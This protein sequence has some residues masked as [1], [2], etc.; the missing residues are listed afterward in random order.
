MGNAMKSRAFLENVRIVRRGQKEVTMPE[1]RLT[2]RT[3]DDIPHPSSG[4]IIYRDTM[5]P[6]FGLRVGA[7][8]KA[9]IVEGQVNRRTRRVTLRAAKRGAFWEI[10]PTAST[11]LLRSGSDILRPLQLKELSESSLLPVRISR[12]LLCK[13]ILG[14]VS[15]TLSLGTT[16]RS[17]TRRDKWC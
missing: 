14:R 1:L 3:V 8:S 16:R 10:W 15:F 12:R 6:G 11:R 9:Y 5:L 2:R 7:K 13:T 4:Q 17:K